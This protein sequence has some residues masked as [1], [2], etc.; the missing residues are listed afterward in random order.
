MFS[1]FLNKIKLSALFLKLKSYSFFGLL[2]NI[3]VRSFGCIQYEILKIEKLFSNNNKSTEMLM[4]I[5][6]DGLKYILL[7]HLDPVFTY[8]IHE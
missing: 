3:I 5:K 4:I 7:E 6:N 8:L 1:A 2:N